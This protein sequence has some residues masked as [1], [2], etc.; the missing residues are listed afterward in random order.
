MKNPL[1]AAATLLAG[2][3]LV[4]MLA[5]PTQ[6]AGGGFA[7][8]FNES[9]NYVAVPHTAALNSFP[10]TVTAWIQTTSTNGQQGLVNKYVAN[11]LNGWNLFLHNGHVRG[12]YFVSCTRNL[13]DGGDGLDSGPIA[14]GVWHHVAMVVDSSGALLY[15]DGVQVDSLAWIGAPGSPTT[16]QEL[17]LGNYPGGILGVPGQILLDEVTVWRVALSQAQILARMNVGLTGSE[18]DLLAYYRCDEGSGVSVADSA[19][20]DGNNNGTW[21][22]ASLFKSL[23]ETLSQSA[24]TPTQATLN[25]RANLPGSIASGWFEFGFTTN[26]G[27][28]TPPQLVGGGNGPTNFS[29]TVTG[30]VFGATYHFRGVASNA[31]GVAL[32]ADQ[33]FHR[34]ARRTYVKASNADASDLFG[35][36][37]AI[38]GDTLVIGAPQE[39]SNA[40]GENGDQNNNSSS[41]SGAAYVFVR[42]GNSWVQQAYLK[43]SNTGAQDGFGGSVALSGDTVIV[44]AA[45]RAGFLSFFGGE[46]SDATG[47]NGDGNNNNA[48]ESGAA[49]VF[50]RNGTNWSQQ[51]YLKASNTGA[52]DRFGVSVAVSGD[53]A[54]V[55][56]PLED[57]NATGVNGNQANNSATN[58]G[59]AYVFVRSG[60]NWAQ[61]AYLKAPS[62]SVDGDQFG[63]SVAISGGSVSVGVPADQ[64]GGLISGAVY[65]FVRNGSSWSQQA[66]LKASNA[67]FFDDFGLSLAMSGDTIVVGA[68]LED[69]N[70]NGVNG[71][72][73][74]N[75]AGDSGAAY[76]F[77]RNG[78]NWSQQ[79]YLKASNTGA[80]DHFGASVAISADTIVV[81]ATDES[82]NATTVNG[83][84]GDNS[85]SSAGAAYIFLRIGT[86][87]SFQDY[88]KASNA[89]AFDSFAY[90]IAVSGDTVVAG[91]PFESGNATGINCDERNN[92]ATQS[93]AA[94]VFGPPLP[95]APEINVRFG[96]NTI[97]D[98]AIAPRITTAGT[99]AADFSIGIANIGSADLTGLTI[100][101]DGPDAGMFTPTSLP[102]SPLPPLDA[103]GFIVRFAATSTGLKT[104][105][106]HIA[107]NDED[108]NPFDIG[109]VGLA[110]SFTEDR[111]GDGLSDAAEFQLAPFGFDFESSQPDLVNLL[112]S[113]LGGATPNLNAI[114]FFTQSQLQAL[115][116]QSPLLAKDPLTGLF[117]ITIGVQKA[118]LLTNFATFPMSGPQTTINLQGKLEFQFSAP[119]N[120]AFFRLESH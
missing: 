91:A 103:T 90:S 72:G 32:G 54:V 51:A 120:A 67:G 79:A 73:N 105:A 92:S 49:Y 7:L 4:L 57:S 115:N 40:T 18:A 29:E 117:K 89:D 101:V 42:S 55:G 24:V 96:P 27:S 33:S 47:I 80:S 69:S 102:R 109:L 48:P 82:S 61:Q 66:S 12:W 62:N 114:G 63:T 65:V 1:N 77:V 83:D 71:D 36:A 94:Y 17:R 11:S 5:A 60:T 118:T 37:I 70:A 84:G 64:S 13:W 53:T 20:L 112:F 22:G 44:G 59:A 45:G 58:S 74:N 104:A 10:L 93:G 88:L 86:N 25:G 97:L 34:S 113:N 110:L 95:P 14:N 108:E 16:T 28:V 98:G 76:V 9:S 68:P 21:V 3:A 8:N 19:P 87:W 30:L 41:G 15:V 100:T 2:L 81:G 78:T 52:G 116:V 111:D 35:S 38:S 43:A 31:F 46:D 106:L 26:Y 85:A 107:S 56:A 23:V 39:S 75:S 50:V 99:N 6:A 119:D